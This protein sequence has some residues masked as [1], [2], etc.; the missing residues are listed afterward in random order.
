MNLLRRKQSGTTFYC[1]T[2]MVMISTFLV[3]AVLLLYVVLRYKLNAAGRIIAAL[4]VFLASFQLA[5]Y[6]VCE[7][8]PRAADDWS[9]FGFVAITLLP[10]LGLY[11]VNSLSPSRMGKRALLA[12]LALCALL[13]IY[14][15]T[16]P[17]II[18]ATCSGNYAIFHLPI[19]FS[20]LHGTYYYAVVFGSLLLARQAAN[21]TKARKKRQALQWYMV[22]LLAFFIPAGIIAIFNTQAMKALPSIMCGFAVILALILAFKIAPAVLKKR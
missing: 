7:G 13:I 10:P 18:A 14:L 17:N 2:P 8:S 15:V 22:G 6:M 20:F 19:L 1:F 12:A 4:L 16:A 11:L 3:E 5:E 21:S 9:R